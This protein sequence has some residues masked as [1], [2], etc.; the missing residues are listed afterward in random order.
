MF[1]FVAFYNR[2]LSFD[3]V[4]FCICIAVQVLDSKNIPSEVCVQQNLV[5]ENFIDSFDAFRAKP[6]LFSHY[7]LNDVPTI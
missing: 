6:F 4:W 3:R 1:H 7:L 5:L 2:I